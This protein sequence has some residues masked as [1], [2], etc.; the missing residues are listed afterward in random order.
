MLE[1][2]GKDY[3]HDRVHNLS[4]AAEDDRE[5]SEAADYE[6]DGETAVA[7]HCEN[8]SAASSDI[9]IAVAAVCEGP[10]KIVFL[11]NKIEDIVPLD[12]TQADDVNQSQ[13]QASGLQASIEACRETGLLKLVQT[14]ELK[15]GKLRRRERTLVRDARG[16]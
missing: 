13:L 12:A 14:L 3:A 16:R 8:E 9:E 4:D 6:I 5:E 1:N 7:A 10:L 11:S 15:I 2:L